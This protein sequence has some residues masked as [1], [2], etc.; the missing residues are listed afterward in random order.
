M[1][2]VHGPLCFLLGFLPFTIMEAIIRPFAMDVLLNIVKKD[3][4]TASSL[5]NFVPTLLSSLGMMA[6]TLPW[7]D[8]IMGLAILLALATAGAV[9]IYGFIRSSGHSIDASHQKDAAI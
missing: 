5:I 2:L 1:R 6:G 7:P 9:V 8:F 4:G 3:I